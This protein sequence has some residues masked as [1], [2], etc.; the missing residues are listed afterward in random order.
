M[1]CCVRTPFALYTIQWS[2]V[3]SKCQRRRKR[4]A[5]L[6]CFDV[7]VSGNLDGSYGETLLHKAHDDRSSCIP[8]AAMARSCL[9]CIRLICLAARSLALS[10]THIPRFRPYLGSADVRAKNELLS[11]CHEEYWTTE[12]DHFS[13][14]ISTIILWFRALCADWLAGASTMAEVLS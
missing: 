14:V 7:Y 5:K 8:S 2:N 10:Q 9:H 4:Y 11:T 12:L 13:W 6:N 3:E 1:N